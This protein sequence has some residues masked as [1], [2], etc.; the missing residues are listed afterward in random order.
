MIKIFYAYRII[1]LA[2]MLAI[3]GCAAVSTATN[4]ALEVVG[5]KK[6]EIPELPDAQKLPRTIQ[7]NLHAS[8]NLNVD[9][10]GRP[11]ALI[12]RVYKLR[13]SANF[14]QTSYDTFL[15]PQKEKDVLGSDLMEV[16]E[17][18]L[19][20]GQRYHAEEKVSQEAYFIGVVALFRSPANQ[21]WRATFPAADVEKTGITIGMHACA[22]TVGVGS[23]IKLVGDDI[24]S[25]S[26]VHCQ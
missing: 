9:A 24:A 25:L 7:I 16:K 14:Q 5:V 23:A 20:P 17:I 2:I 15:N 11:L 10:N 26:S 18:T 12:A 4:S 3:S 1:G 8:E 21:R 13:Q 19:V 22:L 6:P